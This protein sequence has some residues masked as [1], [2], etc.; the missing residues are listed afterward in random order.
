MAKPKSKGE[1]AAVKAASKAK[2]PSANKAA[3][4]TPIARK[5]AATQPSGKQLAKKPVGVKPVA[6][7]PGAKRPVTKKPGAKK[8]AAKAK[9]GAKKPVA[10]ARPGAKKPV[11]KAK[12]VAKKPVGT[13]KPVAKKPVGTAKPVAAKK[14][15]AAAQPATRQLE[16]APST[17][18]VQERG[19]GLIAKLVDKVKAVVARPAE[20]GKRPPPPAS[21]TPVGLSPE[22]KARIQAALP[23]D[24]FA[25]ELRN[26]SVHSLDAWTHADMPEL[27]GLERWGRELATKDLEAGI[28][29]LVEA[30]RFGFPRA[31]EAGREELVDVG[32]FAD[33]PSVDGA[34]VETQIE[35][36]AAWLDNPDHLD[37]V[38]NAFDQTRQ[39]HVWEDDLRPED[40]RAY[41]WYTEVG[42]CCCAAIIRDG[43]TADGA[44][45]YEW[46][47]ATIVGRGLVMAVRGVRQEETNVDEILDEMRDA[48]LA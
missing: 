23:E 26:L 19:K 33:H 43:G 9:P 40:G 14:P 31:A 45:Y 18:R 3:A 20:S 25:E 6:T 32:F 37:A 34:P 38:K 36:A 4:K 47:P 30:A 12:P 27:M 48:M 44:S 29:A 1:K 2:T 46:D 8:P 39:V 7:K 17:I 11:A 13:A 41:W 10:K 16:L 35:V 22:L 28:A 24:S 5:V 42:Q 21:K 15:V